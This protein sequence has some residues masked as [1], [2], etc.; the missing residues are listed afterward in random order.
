MYHPLPIV[1]HNGA[2]P[3]HE[4]G[5]MQDTD[6]INDVRC[7]GRASGIQP[8]RVVVVLDDPALVDLGVGDGKLP[9]D[10]SRKL[11][12]VSLLDEH[13]S[14]LSHLVHR[15]ITHRLFLR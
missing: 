8:I 2:T 4:L 6:Q 13:V 11:A 9:H 15:P 10:V 14:M 5:L 3:T 1:N 7:I 12:D